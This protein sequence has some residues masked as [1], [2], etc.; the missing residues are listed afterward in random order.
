MDTNTS[1]K[2]DI[3]GRKFTIP[4]TTLLKLPKSKLAK[5]SDQSPSYNVETGEHCFNVNSVV[6]ES[7]MDAYSEHSDGISFYGENTDCLFVQRQLQFWGLDVDALA[8]NF[9]LR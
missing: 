2:L 8:P 1:L 9:K 6:F 7:I 4:R 3:R 5:L